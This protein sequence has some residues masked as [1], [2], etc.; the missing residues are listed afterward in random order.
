MPVNFPANPSLN[1]TYTFSGRTWTW[2]GT[3][4]DQTPNASQAGAINGIPVGNVTPATGAFT[5]LSVTGN[6]LTDSYR[7]AN[8]DPF[9]SSNYGDSNVATYLGAIGGNVLPAANITY[10]LGSDTNRWRDIYLANST[11]H[12]GSQQISA[13]GSGLNLPSSVSIGNVTLDTSSGNLAL[14]AGSSI[15]GA[16]VATPRIASIDYPGDDTAADPAGGQTLGIVGSGFVSGASVILDGT[17]L[18]TVTVVSSTRIEITAPA[19][20]AGSYTLY[21]INSDGGT[22]IFIPGVQYSGLPTWSSP[23]AGSLGTVY[24]TANVTA[25]FSATSDSSV[26]YSLLSGD[27]PA[28]ASLDSSTG[29]LS[30]TANLI[31]GSSVTYSFTIRAT[32]AE[33]QDTDRAFSLTVDADSV[34]W[35]SPTDGD[36]ISVPVDTAS[37]TTL[38]AVSA[39]GDS[40]TFSANALPTGFTLSGNTISGTANVVANTSVALTATADTTTRSATVTV[41]FSITLPLG[42]DYWNQ[43]VLLINGDV[44]MPAATFLSDASTNNFEVSWFNEVSS[45]RDSP[46]LANWSN[47]FD[48]SDALY[49]ASDAAF[50][51]GT[52]AFTLEAWVNFDENRNYNT[53]FST[54]PTNT[55]QSTNRF[56][57][58]G[59][60]NGGLIVYS[61]A[62]ILNATNAGTFIPRKWQHFALVREGTGTNQAR[63]Y[64]DGVLVTTFTLNRDGLSAQQMVV[65]A[66][67]NA[68]DALKG[69]ISNARVIKGT[70]LYFGSTIT[71][72]TAPL[73]AITNTS[74]LTCQSNRLRDASTNDLDITRNGDVKVTSFSPFADASNDLGSGSFDGVN[75]Y[76]E[77]PAASAGA[78]MVG[79]GDYTIEGWFRR[80]APAAQNEQ[81]WQMEGGPS[82]LWY[83]N[84]NLYYQTTPGSSTAYTTVAWISNGFDHGWHHYAMTRESGTVRVYVDGK[85]LMSSSTSA[86]GSGYFRIGNGNYGYWEGNIADFR[87]VIGTAV[88]TGGSTKGDVVFAPPTASLTAVSG[89]QLLILQ[90]KVDRPNSHNPRDL[91]VWRHDFWPSGNPYKGAFNPAST[92]GWSGYFDGSSYFTSSTA[93][94]NYTTGNAAT[95]TFT[96]EAWVYHTARTTPS[97]I[98]YSQSIAGKGDVYLN[99]GINGSGNLIFYHYDGTARTITG[100]SVIALN[101]WTN[102]AVVVSGGTATIYV[103]G[104]SDGSGTW[105]GIATAGQN[106]T[107]YFGRP[108][109]NASA[110]YFQGYVS[111]L[112]VS[113]NARSISVPTTPYT[114]DGN[115]SLLTLRGPSFTDDGAN[116]LPIN[117]SGYAQIAPFSPFAPH[118]RAPLSHSVYF[119]GEASALYPPNGQN[120]LTPGDVDYTVEGWYMLTGSYKNYNNLWD[121]RATNFGGGYQMRLTSSGYLQV[122]TT[123]ALWTDNI[124]QLLPGVWYHVA[125]VKDATTSEY[126]IYLNGTL[127]RTGSS[128]AAATSG[129]LTIG[130]NTNRTTHEWGGFI[131]NF[132]ITLSKVYTGNFTVPSSLLSK[133]QSS[134]TNI[135]AIT[136]SYEVALLTCQSPT[137]TDNSDNAFAITV[138]GNSQPT[139]FNPF[140]ETVTDGV[141]YAPASHGSSVNFN[142]NNPAG[143]QL[144]TPYSP[145]FNFHGND[146]T[147]ECWIYV[148]DE[149]P[150]GNYTN[151]TIVARSTTG[152]GNWGIYIASTTTLDTKI[153]FKTAA[154]VTVEHGFF[155]YLYSWVH[156]AWTYSGGTHRMFLNGVQV[157]S[158]SAL[159]TYNTVSD[160]VIGTGSWSWISGVKITNGRAVYT[161]NFVPDST[162][163]TAEADSALVLDPSDIVILDATG[164]N[165]VEMRGAATINTAVTKYNSG[166]I[167]LIDATEPG[168]SRLNVQAEPHLNFPGAFTFEAWI[169]PTDLSQPFHSILGKYG[170]WYWGVYGAASSGLVRMLGGG[171]SVVVASAAGAVV[172][173]Q[174]QHL[175]ITRDNNNVTRIFVNGVQS[176][177]NGSNAENFSNTTD[178]SVGSYQGTSNGYDWRGYLDDIRMTRGLARYTSNFTPPTSAL[179]R[180]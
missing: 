23:A 80:R 49:T 137:V 167:Q 88:Y 1:D 128:G 106:S 98:Y 114:N 45:S 85:F 132:R 13:D 4:W 6:I 130:A 75:D 141:E 151:G 125:F 146:F 143:D 119:D 122:T 46:Y 111:N 81:L 33:N 77:I 86:A 25:T 180:K 71:V 40:I 138:N 95:Q 79:T 116:R 99:F 127:I 115:T 131:S 103:D 178:L 83:S 54:R 110:L 112:R 58:G 102:V 59:T 158:A 133:T 105:Y 179:P 22:G 82:L 32:D 170:N 165:N 152:S 153:Q 96:I 28:G 24:E 156:V 18:G 155:D 169:Y 15:D 34:T 56:S 174:W 78:L 2:N 168:A 70:V 8:G 31:A 108:D 74:L 35:A 37:T 26:T 50:G 107:S 136:N 3:Y 63:I 172:V 11:I 21:V 47:Y 173:D 10:D 51:F 27:L 36:T 142:Y 66:N 140:G 55:D 164:R 89:T 29:V 166:S 100:S 14:P 43:T 148:K 44:A 53:I 120:I 150:A 177:S 118:T 123:G 157:A 109:T 144:K 5:E 160:L 91:S 61:G 171:G 16:A 57:V 93:L 175:A 126:Y 7:Y 149:W 17:S 12:L 68:T 62:F 76:L 139:Q 9:V 41:T 145:A 64:V 69:Y 42:D 38:S 20:S 52:G 73:T 134:D 87:V 121:W 159:N 101:T 19:K 72:P 147:V 135:S 176:G 117:R 90:N 161:S 113:D 97:Q 94:F 48:G 60:S 162:P 65:G 163:P 124:N 92:S 84:N 129:R 39:A 104:V 30:G 154:T 67:A